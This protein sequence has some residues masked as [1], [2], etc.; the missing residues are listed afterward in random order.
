MHKILATLILALFAVSANADRIAYF[1]TSFDGGMPEGTLSV[2]R[3]E[4]TLHFT[5][6]QAGF[7]QGDAWKVFALDGNSYAASPARH[8][9]GKGET[10]LAAD[11]WMILPAVRIM[12]ADATIDWDAKTIAE[13]I[14]EGCAYEVRVSTR[15]NK[16]EDFTDD[17]VF[18][19]DEET[20]GR[21]SRHSVSLAQYAGQEVWIA[22]V[23]TS[24]N[25]EILAV[26]NI[27]VGGSAGLY[28]ITDL[29]GRFQYAPWR[30]TVA[31]QLK[32]TSAE[33][34]TSFTAYCDVDG[35]TFTQ[36]FEGVNLDADSPAVD[37]T[38]PLSRSLNPG[39]VA[40][41]SLRVEVDGNAGVEQPAVEGQLT[42]M[43]FKTK[44]RVVAEE[45]TGMWCG[46][47]PRGIVAMRQMRE[48]YSDDFIGIAVHYDD[49]LYNAVK[50]YCNTL[51]FPS[52]PSAYINR[53]TLCGDPMPLDSK[54]QYSCAEGL[55]KACLGAIEDDAPADL[56]L[57]W[58]IL[59]DG[60][61]GLVADAHF[62]ITAHNSDY[63]F[64]AVAV[65]DEV[66]AAG[67]YQTNYYS[68]S[69]KP[70]GGFESEAEKI[71]PFTFDEVA[72]AALLPFGGTE[73]E[74][75]A[76]VEAN[77]HYSVTKELKAPTYSNLANVRVVLMLLDGR[78]GEVLNAVQ[79]SA[80]SVD[81]YNAV[82]ASCNDG[83]HISDASAPHHI[84]TLDGR[85]A[86]NTRRGVVI[87]DGRKTLR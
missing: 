79:A 21:W 39:D 43:L 2:D 32:A 25:R 74:I 33:R 63:R 52:Y 78:S 87:E 57:T 3:D 24:L 60:K 72:R 9:V 28:Q 38:F 69:A 46:Y 5:M 86:G 58:T 16:P 27:N 73:G 84:Y 29:T 81:E 75:S 1:A 6:V 30:P 20:I 41:Y 11:D 80:V 18:S 77:R 70:L 47:C 13:S 36:R 55:E 67:Y 34:I 42:Y 23:H 4:Q 85:A 44:R 17:A 12:A 37:L 68:G 40:H 31:A 35:E 49:A 65:E 61:L 48:K 15:G 66:S 76:T 7:D 10:A 83:L 62:A 56:A 22:F 19:I 71:V 82:L 53:T 26:D 50:D 51:Y 64:T 45:G 54:G 59:P 8:K 14:D